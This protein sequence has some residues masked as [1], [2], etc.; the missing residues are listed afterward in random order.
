MPRPKRPPHLKYIKDTFSGP[1]YVVTAAKIA[2]GI[3][4][5]NEFSPW[6][7]AAFEAKLERENPGLLE[8]TRAEMAEGGYTQSGHDSLLAA[9]GKQAKY[10]AA[11]ALSRRASELLNQPAPKRPSPTPARHK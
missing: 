6:V 7:V 3:A 9:E 1:G 4:E 8:K 10:P 11:D 2:A 5:G